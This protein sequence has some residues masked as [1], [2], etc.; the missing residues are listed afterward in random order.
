MAGSD[1]KTA[2][3]IVESIPD[4]NRR[5]WG[6]SWSAG[7]LGANERRTALDW[8]QQARRLAI[9]GADSSDRAEGLAEA[10]AK[11]RD[12]GERDTVLA[13]FREAAVEALRPSPNERA[14]FVRAHI[15]WELAPLDLKGALDLVPVPF[16]ADGRDAKWQLELIRKMERATDQAER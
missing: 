9:E 6:L 15:A 13:V 14:E 5:A 10:A 2:L 16:V 4:S 11:Y 1:L 7:E 12:L 8:P 3:A